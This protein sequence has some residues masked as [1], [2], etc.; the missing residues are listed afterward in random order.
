VSRPSGAQVFVDGRF[1]GT[2]PLRLSDVAAGSHAVR[3]A[4]PGHRR[5]VTSVNVSPG[6]RSRVA[7]SLER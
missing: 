3:I 2:T 7:A 5:W 6:E 1:V 4:L